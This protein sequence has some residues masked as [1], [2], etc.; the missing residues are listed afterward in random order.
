MARKLVTTLLLGAMMALGVASAQATVKFDSGPQTAPGSTQV[1][2][3]YFAGQYFFV[4]SGETERTFTDVQLYL[5]AAVSG[6]MPTVKLYS[7]DT[8]ANVPTNLIT[9]LSYSSKSSISP[10][11]I[12]TY[13]ANVTLTANTGYWIVMNGTSTETFQWARTGDLAGVTGAWKPTT[14]TGFYNSAFANGA[15]ATQWDTQYDNRLFKMTVNATAV[16]EPS[17]YVLLTLALGAVG[18]ARRKMNRKA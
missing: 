1:T 13:N 2:D 5:N 10:Y 16:P 9:T 15:G 3:Q 17:T 14:G 6:T 11:D 18:F 7:G 4:P 8:S 12:Y